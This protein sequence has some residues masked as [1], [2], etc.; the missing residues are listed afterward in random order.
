MFLEH[1]WYIYNLSAAIKMVRWDWKNW[2]EITYIF[3]NW[4][5][6]YLNSWEHRSTFEAARDY[7]HKNS[8]RVSDYPEG[9]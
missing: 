8:I 3:S 5:S 6:L 7:Y 2:Y 4:D 1:D 9:K